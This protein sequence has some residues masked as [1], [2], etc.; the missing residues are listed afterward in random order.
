MQIRCNEGVAVVYV[1]SPM[2]VVTARGT[3][4]R[5][6]H[7]RGGGPAFQAGSHLQA[8]HAGR[9][10]R[11]PGA[12]GHF[13]AMSLGPRPGRFT[14]RSATPPPVPPGPP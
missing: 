7:G 5:R 13:G 10:A 9:P 4:K 11:V 12:P 8:G 3:P 1:F 14:W 2:G 6:F